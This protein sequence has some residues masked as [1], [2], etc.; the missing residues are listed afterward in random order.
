M[1]TRHYLGIAEE[2]PRNWSISFPAFP[3]TAT[4]G[5]IFSKPV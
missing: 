2:L 4:T 5:D 1:A 3:G